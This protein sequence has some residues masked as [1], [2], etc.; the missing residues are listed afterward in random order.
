MLLGQVI[1]R[2]TG[3]IPKSRMYKKS[4]NV[5][6]GDLLTQFTLREI[7]SRYKQ[8]M[9][10]YVWVILNPFVQMIVM[11]F[12]FSHILRFA[13]IETPYPVFLYIGLLPWIFISQS[14]SSSLNS[15]VGNSSLIT[16]IYFP[17]ETLVLSTVLTKLF[18][19]LLSVCVLVPFLIIY[20]I[21]FL[22]IQLFWL[23]PVLLI[24]GLLSFSLSLLSAALNLFF[25]DIQY[26]VNH[27]LLLWMYL[28]PVIYPESLIPKQYHF[29][30]LL[31]PMAVFI[32]MYREVILSKK[33][34]ELMEMTIV[35]FATLF[36]FV[37]SIIFFRKIEGTFADVV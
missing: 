21:D 26:V 30:L 4:S 13:E 27:V 29:F 35:C 36:V 22:S 11:S 25:R 31:N 7:K 33:T 12:V 20:Q 15:L 24:Q 17:K 9:L 23:I 3:I 34:P 8:S 18:D 5:N 10:G 1:E 32:K 28:T 2:I 16:K 37:L 6:Y 14:I 19:L